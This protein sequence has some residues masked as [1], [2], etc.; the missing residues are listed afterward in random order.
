MVKASRRQAGRRRTGFT[1]VELLVVIAI[2]GILIAMLLPAIQAA[3]EAARRAQCSNNIKQ[4]CLGM[5]EFHDAFDKFPCALYSPNNLP[6]SPALSPTNGYGS[7]DPFNGSP[8]A[9]PPNPSSPSGGVYARGPNWL[10][11]I[12]PFIE[13]PGLYDA[14]YVDIKA[15]MATAEPLGL[16][17]AP[18]YASTA[19]NLPATTAQMAKWKYKYMWLEQAPIK[20]G[21]DDTLCVSSTWDGIQCPSDQGYEST[22]N[23]I[24]ASNQNTICN[25]PAGKSGYGRGNYCV[26]AGPCEWIA[27]SQ[28]RACSGFV[29]SPGTTIY[30]NPP[31]A[32]LCTQNFGSRLAVIVNQDGSSNTACI[33]EVRIGLVPSD[34]RGTWALGFPAASVV[35]GAA[36]NG[37]NVL[38]TG[39]PPTTAPFANPYSDQG[40][41]YRPPRPPAPINPASAYNGGDVI[42][43]AGCMESQNSVG[44]NWN[45]QQEGMSCMESNSATPGIF[46]ATARANHV[47]GVNVGMAD[48]AVRYVMDGM[49][50]RIWF[51][52][53]SRMD[54][55]AYV[56]Q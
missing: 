24:P 14:M 1:L 4:L 29:V 49:N 36:W 37:S 11:M 2:I 35:V 34:I 33:V 22:N 52:I 15:P 19:S 9:T 10:V 13:Q 6:D 32:G 12:L 38:G 47:A 51:Q 3:R 45:L 23:F 25:N 48:G 16:A 7:V 21:V 42:Y 44:G 8:P 56:I 39:T 41:N 43:P 27:G 40:P 5:Q 55:E 26:N 50:G 53:L 20:A 18:T 30:K 31:G 28:A 54:G 17:A 46:S